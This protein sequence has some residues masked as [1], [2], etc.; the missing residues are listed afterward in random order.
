MSYKVELGP[1]AASDV[2][3]IPSQLRRHVYQ[4]LDA[5]GSHPTRMSKSI[6]SPSN[7][8]QLYEF[9][10]VYDDMECW[11]SSIFQYGVDEQTLYI[12]HVRWEMA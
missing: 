10:F 3:A 2:A 7:V 12:L 8:G 4:G 9:S 1:V 11:V 5:L 6:S